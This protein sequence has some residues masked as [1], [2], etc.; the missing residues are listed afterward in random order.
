MITKAEFVDLIIDY[1][2][3]GK[4]IDRHNELY[5][6]SGKFENF[7]E[8]YWKL[9]EKHLYVY[10]DE[11]G[12]DMIMWWLVEKDQPFPG[13]T[14]KEDDIDTVYDLWDYIKEHFK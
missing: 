6:F 8:I 13:S 2:L 5:G 3:H 9:F 1:K 14:P 10:F 7:C 12:V 4:F 11:D